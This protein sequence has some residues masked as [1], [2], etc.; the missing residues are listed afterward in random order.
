MAKFQIP[1]SR[2]CFVTGLGVLG[3]VA[4]PFACRAADSYTLRFNV[5]EPATSLQC[6]TAL[7]LAA[8]V[9]RRSNGQLKIEVYPLFQ[10]AKEGETIEALANGV[11]DLAVMSTTVLSGLVPRFQLFDTPFLFNDFASAF[12]VLDGAIGTE[13]A[14]EIEPRG[15]TVLGWGTGGFREFET[16][17]KVVLAPEDLKGMRIRVLNGA[18]YIA[19]YQALGAIPIVIDPNEAFIALS[20]H[21]VE[22]VDLSL[23]S[24]TS[25][26]MYTVVK[27]VALLNQVF[28]PH[29]VFA[30]KRKLDAM[31]VA[32]QRLLRNEATIQIGGWRSAVAQRLA[33]NIA[34]LK[35]NG[36][37]FTDPSRAAFR[38]AMGPV[39]TL[40]Q[41]KIGG[42][43]LIERAIR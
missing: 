28:S 4:I 26:K 21:V 29:A 25:Q 34:L 16:T 30:S 24:F 11:V 2:R 42:G 18:V 8:S 39:Y 38:K 19:T 14:A 23:D 7:K 13:L 35:A 17:S 27:H 43:D 32:L 20:N 37:S 9:E 3:T 12:R 5:A 33:T 6:M 41:S 36:V 10:L 22:A 1:R 31:P 40:V 15:V